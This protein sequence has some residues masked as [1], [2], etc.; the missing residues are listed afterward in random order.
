MEG[1]ICE[2]HYH[3]SYSYP[4]F[5][6][7]LET[8]NLGANTTN[9]ESM[10]CL[11][12]YEEISQPF[13]AQLSQ[14]AKNWQQ[15]HTPGLNS[16]PLLYE[17][18]Q[19]IPQSIPWGSVVSQHPT[20]DPAIATSPQVVSSYKEGSFG[21]VYDSQD[22]AFLNLAFP[23]SPS[24]FIKSEQSYEPKAS[25]GLGV[26]C[27]IASPSQCG[28]HPPIPCLQ[29][30]F[31]RQ[32]ESMRHQDSITAV[33]N[34]PVFTQ[35]GYGADQGGNIRLHHEDYKVTNGLE[36]EDGQQK[37]IGGVMDELCQLEDRLQDLNKQ[38]MS[39]VKASFVN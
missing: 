34:I 35:G 10:D 5:T 3:K 12:Q 23:S 11:K 7:H 6:T 15:E 33:N 18:K 16:W 39:F 32:D 30:S 29:L 24:M 26:D 37:Y 1:G 20:E 36:T 22:L 38:Q 28:I 17:E 13:A 8:S 9:Q 14:A 25:V 27:I 4:G 19:W 21:G 2:E 31:P